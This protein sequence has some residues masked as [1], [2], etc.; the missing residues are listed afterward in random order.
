[1]PSGMASGENC[2]LY[3]YNTHRLHMQKRENGK[4]EKLTHT[5][6]SSETLRDPLGT[7]RRELVSFLL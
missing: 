2:V 5:R 6:R 7:I 4:E 3:P 1:M